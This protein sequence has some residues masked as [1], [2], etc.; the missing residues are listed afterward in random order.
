MQN[1]GKQVVPTILNKAW[2]IDRSKKRWNGSTQKQ[3][4]GMFV[5]AEE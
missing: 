4:R 3:Y 2:I 1:N 5:N